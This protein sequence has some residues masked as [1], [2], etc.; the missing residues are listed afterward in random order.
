MEL[1]GYGSADLD[2]R[3]SE[4][5]SRL[6]GLLDERTVL[7]M[8][9]ALTPRKGASLDVLQDNL[10]MCINVARYLESH[11][12][13]ACVYISSDAVYSFR[14]NPVTETTPIEPGNFYALAKYAGERI[15]A[16]LAEAAGTR[17]LIVRPA[18]LY[19]P[20]DPHGSYGPN[21]FLRSIVTDK[22]VRILGEG[23]ERR[24]HVHV[25]DAARLIRCLLVTRA[26]GILNLATGRSRSFAEIVEILRDVVS[27][28]FQTVMA[29]RRAPVTHRHF[30]VTR[31]FLHVPQF[32]FTPLERGL[33]EYY[34]SS[35][36]EMGSG[37]KVV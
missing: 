13:A 19:G 23:E 7:I 31:L 6:D 37:E 8:A 15:F 34:Q 16:R 11:H 18:A 1:T 5:L 17:L 21:G 27:L 22:T 35:L 33:A 20:G 9:S 26:T 32:E 14:N 12:A 4:T 29:P 24:D 10:L 36:R 2:L 30:D 25:E 3:R 28:P